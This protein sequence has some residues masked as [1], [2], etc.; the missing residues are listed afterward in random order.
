MET[1]EKL[2]NL[3]L[4][5]AAKKVEKFSD[6]IDLLDKKLDNAVGAKS[7]NK[8]IDKQTKEEK[9]T[10]DAYKEADRETKSAL[11]SAK[12]ELT[13]SK[14]LGKDDGIT[15]AEKKKIKAAVK[16]NEAL[17]ANTQSAYD[18]KAAQEDYRS[19]LSEAATQKF[20]NIQSQYENELGLLEHRMSVADSYIK[21]AEALGHMVSESYYR[22]LMSQEQENIRELT[23]EREELQKSL[24][25]AMADGSI[26][27]Y[28]DEWYELTDAIN[29]VTS[30]INDATVS[31]IEYQKQLRQL[32]WD[33]F[34]MQ[35]GYI[36]RIQSES[37][38][39]AGIMENRKLFD[40]SG[41]WTEYADATA[42]L[43]AVNYNAYMAQADDYAKELA[44]I[45]K[46]LAKDPYDTAV[47]KRK[48]ELLDL[49][50]EA[51]NNAENEKQSI[52]S[53]V[54][55]GYNALL[56]A[57]KKIADEY[58]DALSAQKDL[59]EYEKSIRKQTKNVSSLEKQ[60]LS[61]EGDGSEETRAKL[62]K[63]KTQ[64]EDARNELADSEYDQWV[65]DQEKMLDSMTSEMEE[66][67][68]G[69]LDN[70]E[71]LVAD[72]IEKTNANS[73]EINSTLGQV[74]KDV[75]Y[76]LTPEM[77][78]IWN[79]GNGISS[80]V[81]MYEENFENGFTTVNSTLESIRDLVQSMTDAGNSEA[82]SDLVKD[83]DMGDVFEKL[84]DSGKMHEFS[85]STKKTDTG[86]IIGKL[87]DSGKISSAVATAVAIPVLK[88]NSDK[89]TS[90]GNQSK[91]TGNMDSQSKKVKWGSWFRKKKY[92][93]NKKQLDKNGSVTDRLRYLD[94][95]S[96][97]AMRKTYYEAMGGK[98]T[99]TNSKTQN[100]WMLEQMKKHGFRSGGT[101]GSLVNKTGEDGFVLARTGE[102]IL[103]LEKIRELGNAFE[104]IN[105]VIDSIR[106]AGTLP[107]FTRV[108]NTTG[109][110]IDTVNIEFTLP[111]VKNYEEF[112]T[113]MRT[114]KRFEGMVQNMTLGNALGK[115]SFNKL[116]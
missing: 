15:K 39:L 7:K 13:K 17:K 79:T 108:Q 71:G 19:W 59:Y 57:V 88:D 115:N 64:L 37:E 16:Y 18:L 90:S 93:G 5:K 50:Q 70:L 43:Y 8:L 25:K 113:K 26:D 51:I 53:L 21:K 58:R 111:N 14:N 9:K 29:E 84:K 68:N 69:R 23:K 10:L 101:I 24:E 89:N 1:A 60:V 114:D 32:A 76:A 36:S 55:D 78:K 22:S 98:G 107:E 28:S 44:D 109:N 62:Q 91:I 81:S 46:E 52:R 106:A 110:S 77:E 96:S 54:S 83:L 86:S 3:P 85:D 47:I 61:L 100:A 6:S 63:L 4:D 11:K 67:M 30:A 97:L 116:R 31:A 94:Y 2:Y 92:T 42:G 45:E 33:R 48:Q 34:D 40:D 105:P 73:G 49:Q 38:F 72:I 56:D 82:F 74:G 99:Y 112:M 103:S 27:K 104:R 20:G 41:S 95:D 35:Q 75:G 80:I 65:N 102:E 12:K 66:W 87:V